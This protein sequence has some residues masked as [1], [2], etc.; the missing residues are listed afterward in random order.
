MFKYHFGERE[1]R[2]NIVIMIK[3]LALFAIVALLLTSCGEDCT[4]IKKELEEVKQEL[5]LRDTMIQQIGSTFGMIDSN[6]ISLKNVE[7]ELMIKLRNPNSHKQAIQ[8][9]VQKMKQIMD[10]NQSY[11]EQLQGN[12]RVSNATTTTLFSI[13]NSMEEKVMNNNLRLARLN[14]DLSSLGEDFEG[15][16]DEYMQAEVSRMVMEENLQQMEGNVTNMEAQMEELKNQMNTVFVAIGTKRELI[17]S[18]VLEKGGLL[19]HSEV[20]EDFDPMLFRPHDMREIEKLSLQTDKARIVTEH[21]SESYSIK[22][23]TLQIEAPKLFWSISKY[24]I[25]ITD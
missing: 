17:D 15:L 1:K 19:Q 24:L 12:L 25:V 3:K 10:M 21:P 5:A 20:N 22:D 2:F 14:T 23:Q 18:G 6:L 8:A 16:F 7:A 9:N 11:I 4:P 13:I